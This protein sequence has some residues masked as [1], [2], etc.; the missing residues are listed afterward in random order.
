MPEKNIV[1]TLKPEELPDYLR[2]CEAMLAEFDG[3][4]REVRETL[5]TQIEL[6]K[7]KIN[8]QTP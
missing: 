1:E 2:Y 7:H 4:S 8:E 3:D 6:V 5:R